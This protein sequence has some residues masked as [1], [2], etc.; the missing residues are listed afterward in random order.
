MFALPRSCR[1]GLKII[2]KHFYV[3]RRQMQVRHLD[4]VV[5]V[6]QRDSHRI[7]FCQ[8]LVWS[9]NIVG[10]PPTA[11][12]RSY[13]EQVWSHTV[14]AADGVAGG[15]TGAEHRGAPAGRVL[16]DPGDALTSV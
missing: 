3:D 12:R 10:E 15:A 4:F 6:E 16:S 11:S 14:T 5:F 7:F 1:F 9:Q 13:A 8:H 2:Q